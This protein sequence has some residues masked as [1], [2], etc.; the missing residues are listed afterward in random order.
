MEQRRRLL[1][2][3]GAATLLVGLLAVVALAAGGRAPLGGDRTEG[4]GPPIV[5]WDYLLSTAVVLCALAVPFAVWLFWVSRPEA[6]RPS[7]R[8]RDVLVL[9]YVAL[10]CAAIVGAS[11][12]WGDEREPPWPRN[13]RLEAQQTAGPRDD[14][15]RTPEFR[16]LPVVVAAGAAVAIVAYQGARA[17]RAASLDPRNEKELGDELTALVDDTLDDLLDEPDPRRAVVSA[18]ARMERVLAAFGVPRHAFEAPLEYLERVAPELERVPGASR[19]VFELTHLYERAKFSPHVIDAE[20][21]EQAIATLQSLR[22]EL[23]APA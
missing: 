1:R 6:R 14:E 12:I 17:R 4:R 10:V 16:W 9:V 7:G 18:Y 15:R 3:L 21:K 8:R 2:A 13:P 11:R 5:F 19:L 22:S 23:L 20:M